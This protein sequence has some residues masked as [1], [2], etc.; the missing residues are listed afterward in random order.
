MNFAFAELDPGYDGF[1]VADEAY[2]DTYFGSQ[3]AFEKIYA[4]S[5]SSGYDQAA[6]FS[7]TLR[8]CLEATL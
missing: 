6:D 5:G 4:M 7:R 8:L 3:V 2:S 1:A